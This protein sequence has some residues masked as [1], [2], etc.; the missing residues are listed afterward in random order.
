MSVSIYAGNFNKD[1]NVKETSI[2]YKENVSNRTNGVNGIFN[3]VVMS[4]GQDN[5]RLADNTYESLLKEADDVKQQIMNS[6][7]TAQISF[8]ALV[9]KLSGMEAV[10][11][12]GDGFNITDA[13]K[14]DMVSIIDKI[15]IEL[16]MHSDSYVAYGTG[17]SS[18]AIE[19]V[20]G[21]GAANELKQRLSGAG[22]SVDDDTAQQ[23]QSALDEAASITELSESAKYYM[24][25]NDI[26]PTIDGIYKAENAVSTRPANSGYEISFK[27]FNAM[28]PQ[29]ES[30]MNKAGLEV[31]LRNLNNAQDLIN[32]NIPVTEKTLKYKAILDGLNLNG[33]DTQAGQDSVLSKIADQLAI[34]E[35]PKDTPLTNDP[36]IWDNVKNAIVT[37]ANASYDDIV[38]VVSSGKAFTIASLKVVM[39]VGWSETAESQQAV[40]NQ[41]TVNNQMSGDW[42]GNVNSQ[43]SGGWQGNV[44]NQYGYV[45]DT[46]YNQGVYNNQMGGNYAY[47][48]PYGYNAQKAYNTLVEAR[49]KN[50]EEVYN[51][52]NMLVHSDIFY[53]TLFTDHNTNRAKGVACT[54]TLYGITGIINEMLVYSDEHTIE[55]LPAWSDKL[56]SGM[57]KGL[58]TRCGITIDE[59]KWDVNKKKVY[60][61]LDWGKTEG[62][63]V[64][65]RN[66]EIEK[67][68][69]E[70]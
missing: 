4:E 36:S 35:D 28:R 60:V 16:A 45:Q 8:K 62:I 5:S 10:D 50:S 49:L 17:V 56:G 19:S 58:R 1:N 11:I 42:Q 21:A 55:L 52:L 7:N 32:N 27:E 6:A 38:N 13:S 29:T 2:N 3:G 33:L 65:C 70:R 59:L 25:A 40:N 46:G 39:Q 18:D 22:I 43:M 37:L 9:K 48:Q 31:N 54:D 23:V 14:D 57:V 44:N 51:I 64:V 47:Q 63:N 68:G 69:H 66:Y 41:M 67:I 26:A 20:A 15:R 12:A 61:S 34:G 30:L 53:S 24:I